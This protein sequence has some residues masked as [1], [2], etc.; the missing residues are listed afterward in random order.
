MRPLNKC[1]HFY[2]TTSPGSVMLFANFGDKYFPDEQVKKIGLEVDSSTHEISRKAAEALVHELNSI[3]FDAVYQGVK[4]KFNPKARPI[5]YLT[6]YS[7]PE[8]AQGEAK[9]RH[10]KKFK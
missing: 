1:V 9:I 7:K 6:V 4:R 5:V 3:G 8:Y 10:Q 2:L